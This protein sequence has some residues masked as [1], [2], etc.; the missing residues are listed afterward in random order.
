MTREGVAVSQQGQPKERKRPELHRS[1]GPVQLALYGLGSMLGAGIYGLIGK[2]AGEV[3]N[4]VWLAFA[5][6][7]VAALLTALSYASLGSRYPRAAG[8]A[9]VTERAFGFPLLSFMIGLAL[10]CSGLT[11][12]ATQ[13]RVFA[14]NMAGCSASRPCRCGCSRSASC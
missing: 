1:I 11:S 8:A 2:A 13:A 12:I 3:G 6:A 9:Y 10:L 5:V 7:L 14:A 4:A